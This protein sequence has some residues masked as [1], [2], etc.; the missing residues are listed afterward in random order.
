MLGVG[1]GSILEHL[2]SKH[3]ARGS[4]PGTSKQNSR[5]HKDP[6]QKDAKRN[7]VTASSL[8]P[9]A[10]IAQ[11]NPEVIYFLWAKLPWIFCCLELKKK[12]SNY[13][14]FPPQNYKRRKS[15]GQ[16]RFFFSRTRTYRIVTDLNVWPQTKTI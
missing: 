6:T 2:F 13:D 10:A 14:C 7:K 4:S 16:L 15:E 5:K 9:S 1:C 3:K 12:N 8:D 11:V